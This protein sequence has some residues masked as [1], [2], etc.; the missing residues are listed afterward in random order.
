MVAVALENFPPFWLH[1]VDLEI[2]S[3][4]IYIPGIILYIFTAYGMRIVIIPPAAEP[5]VPILGYIMQ[6]IIVVCTTSE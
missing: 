6:P 4:S 5:L 3:Q 2:L 1:A